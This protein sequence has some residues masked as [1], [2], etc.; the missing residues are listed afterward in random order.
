MSIVERA[1]A[2]VAMVGT[3]PTIEE[4][5]AALRS[6]PGSLAHDVIAERGDY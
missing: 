1:Q 4:V 2:E 6:I 5:G 3:I